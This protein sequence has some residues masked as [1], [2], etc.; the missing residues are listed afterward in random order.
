MFEACLK[1]CTWVGPTPPLDP[2]PVPPLAERV[3]IEVHHPQREGVL[4]QKQLVFFLK[5]AQAGFFK[6]AA[7]FLGNAL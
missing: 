1:K 5:C 6:K 3:L 2:L 4:P 7:A